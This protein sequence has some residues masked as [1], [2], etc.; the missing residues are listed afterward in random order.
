MTI[1]IK[2]GVKL[3]NTVASTSLFSHTISLFL[4]NEAKINNMLN[5]H[6]SNL[7]PA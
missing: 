6:L 2:T 5:Q 1:G 7:S 4:F 3:D